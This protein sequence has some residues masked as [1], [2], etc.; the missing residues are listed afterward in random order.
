M[1]RFRCHDDNRMSKD[2]SVIKQDCEI[3]HVYS[4]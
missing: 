3:C 4:W 1:G 2:C